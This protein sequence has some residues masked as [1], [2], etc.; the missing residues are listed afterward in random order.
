MKLIAIK[1]YS[2]VNQIKEKYYQC[3]GSKAKLYRK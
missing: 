3:G 2:H 1:V